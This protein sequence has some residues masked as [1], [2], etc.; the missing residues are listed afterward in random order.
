MSGAVC[1]FAASPL[2]GMRPA[3]MQP[4]PLGVP[5]RDLPALLGQRTD[6]GLVVCRA[7]GQW[8]DR[9]SWESVTLAGDVVEF[10]KL[11]QDR[12]SL[13]TVLSI[14]AIFLPQF[15]GLQGAALF[16]ATTAASLAVNL[17]LPPTV[18]QAPGSPQQTGDAS[19]TSLQGNQARLDQPIWKVC[20][21]REIT[22]PFAC[23]PYFEYRAR[24]DAVDEDLDHDQFFFAL[25]AV[26]VG[27]HEVFAKIGN[28]PITRF[29][30]VLRADYL[31][32]GT[33][34][35][36]VL[37]N[38]TTARE[39]AGQILE[40][41][42]Y[43]GGF[44]ACSARRT[45]QAIGVDVAAT[46][47]LGKGEDALT[48]SWRVEYRE[49]N[50]FGQVL[51]PWQV[52]ANESRTGY[53][54]TPQRWSERYELT[55][56]AR[57]EVR[58]VRTDVQDTAP[59]ALHELAWIG[60]RAYLAEPAPLN[61]HT[62]HFEVVMRASAQL[63][64]ASSRDV[65]LIVQ[66][67]CVSLDSNLNDVAAAHTRNPGWWAL[68][69]VRSATWGARKADDRVDLQSFRDFA[70]TCDARQDRF[71]F[72]FDQA[73]SA[74][75]ALQLIARAGRARAFRRNGVISIA[76]DEWIDVPVTAFSARNCIPGSIS[77][78]EA[79]PTSQTPDG[80]VIEYQ[81]HR[82][83]E[84]T[85]I[86]CPCPGVELSD[87]ANP[88]RKR[89][90]GVTGATHAEREGLYEAACIVYRGRS[91]NWT[92]EMQGM[93]PAFLDTVAVQP[94]IAGYGQTGDVVDWSPG[95]LVMTLSEAPDFE[96]GDLYLTLVRDDGTLTDPVL[97]TPGPTPFDVTLSAIP[98][99]TL[100][101][102]AGDRERPKFLIGTVSTARELVKVMS[103]Q[104]GGRT[105][106]PQG[107][108]GPG[109]QLYAL[110]G[111]I[112]DIRVHEAD[113][114]L[115][116]GPGVI[117]D[118]VGLPDDSDEEEGGGGGILLIPR[119]LDRTIQGIT[120]ENDAFDLA[121]EIT[122]RNVGTAFT[123][124]QGANASTDDEL[125]NEWLLYG[126]AEPAQCG[127]FEVRATLLA[128]SNGAANISL[129]GTLDA[130][131]PLSTERSWRLLAEYVDG[132]TSREAVR[133][134]RLEIRE[135]STGI[136]QDSAVISL[137][138]S[139]SIL[140]GGGA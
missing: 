77:Y 58:V 13:R 130:W 66:A 107:E 110:T 121:A 50:D 62:A 89:L 125:V 43:V 124:S 17:L 51:T 79:L 22:P 133:E 108:E 90:E 5:L 113:A 87:M 70:V 28:T 39:V 129:T 74:W 30:D 139:V 109:A 41:G 11:P 72:V 67:K 4:V 2:V 82:T 61:E 1:G 80:V 99:F 120:F 103:I 127:L 97:V 45:C 137:Q 115:L 75:D 122:L 31:P 49:I 96:A 116:P 24:P 10:Y 15:F 55:T 81:D 111:L 27:D 48:V 12:D 140:G 86:P 94:D 126:E 53:T 88:V 101:T 119:I 34:P 128:S 64:Q 93:L 8:I 69:L 112:D 6:D 37:A 35:T 40:S 63:S 33:Q 14:A 42:R 65:R 132:S 9:A 26:G 32:P 68:D 136:V 3:D 105:E 46:R 100:V 52:L 44:A 118:P 106:P 16:A 117:Q 21:Q 47:G 7:N 84:W 20:G 29:A 95:T 91:L 114:A 134:L 18:Q 138:T 36:E 135:T 98:D 23:E 83:G 25:Y 71:D 92:T 104:D 76:R 102:Y 59:F 60:L 131:L 85:E 54:A 78:S 123:T 38:V 73:V 57:V 56:E 19:S